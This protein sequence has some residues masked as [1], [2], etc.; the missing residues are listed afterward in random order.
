MASCKALY[1]NVE[2]PKHGLDEPR[3]QEERSESA[4]SKENLEEDSL[5][6]AVDP[7]TKLEGKPTEQVPSTQP[8]A[9]KPRCSRRVV[10]VTC[11]ALLAMSVIL[12][13]LLLAVGTVHYAKLTATLEQAENENKKLQ[14]TSPVSFLLYNEHHKVCVARQEPFHLTG[15]PCRPDDQAQHFQWLPGGLLRHVA[16][17]LC[18]VA[19]VAKN[20]W[21]LLL[22]RC[23][24]RSPLQRWECR[25]HDL[26]ALESQ[27]LYFNYGNSINRLVILY[28][29][30]GPWSRWL[31]YGSLNNVCNSCTPLGRDWTFFQGK[32]YF[33]SY[34]L[35]SWEVANQSCAAMDSHLVT[36]KSAEEE[37]HVT[38]ILKSST[39]WI[40]LTDQVQ[41]GNWKWV[42]GTDVGPKNSY[43][44]PNE[45]NGGRTENC[46]LLKNSLWYDSSCKES[47][48][49]ICERTL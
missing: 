42:D 44:Q 21:A 4:G 39:S 43:W 16:S 26:L 6:E 10:I 17:Q 14:D 2:V 46:A 12:N 49:W 19:P 7:L 20:K 32:Y 30:Q 48:R 1:I 38:R 28:E 36:I 22:K 29:G 47:H 41:E 8:P 15:V 9:W 40:G 31:V 27:G 3:S 18:V 34:S 25:D 11:V 37:G 45:P 23:N 13:V 24:A 35:A 5:Y 33:F